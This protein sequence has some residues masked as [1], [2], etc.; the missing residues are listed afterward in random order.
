MSVISGLIT[1]NASFQ[2]RETFELMPPEAPQSTILRWEDLGNLGQE[3]MALD[4][5]TSKHDV[6]DVNMKAYHII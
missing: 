1:G 3:E 4:L 5:T 2:K 6:N